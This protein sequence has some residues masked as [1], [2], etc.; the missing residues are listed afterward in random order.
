M[1]SLDVSLTPAAAPAA[2]GLERRVPPHKAIAQ[3]LTLAWRSLVQIRHNPQELLDVSIQ[4]LMFVVL[5]AY[6]F[7]GAISGSPQEYLQ[8][9][10]TG[11]IVQNALFLTLNTAIG[12]NTDVTKGIFDRFRSL[13]IARSSPLA[14]RILADVVRQLWSVLVVL[15]V[16]LALGFRF[17]ASPFAVVGGLLI[18]LAFVLCFSWV[19][20]LIGLLV[21]EPEKVQIFGFVGLFPLTFAS[22]AFVPLQTMPGWMQDWARADPVTMLSDALRGCFVGGPVARPALEALAIGVGIA[23]VFFP[24]ALRA[25]R[26]RA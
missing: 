24:L 5:F 9:G 26:Q 25:F 23:A 15:G 17:H 21:D 20:V 4:P 11:I 13:P 10:L 8:F 22:G 7:G 18:L 1:S 12:L 2:A 19:A 16:G 6:V 14:G 3:S